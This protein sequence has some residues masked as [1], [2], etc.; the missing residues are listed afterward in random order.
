MTSEDS[1]HSKD[2]S[3]LLSDLEDEEYCYL[4]TTGRVSGRPHEI[5]IWFGTRDGTLYLLS[6]GGEQS[7][8][9]KNLRARPSVTVRIRKHTLQGVARGV[10]DGQ[11]DALARRLLA[12]KYQ[13]WSENDPLSDWARTAL[14]VAIDLSAE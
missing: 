4:T 8:W 3:S 11:Q 5:E 1:A 14:P 10:P 13:G 7:D 6:G 9:V 12:A 2:L